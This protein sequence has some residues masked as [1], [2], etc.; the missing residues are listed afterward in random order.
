[1]ER[2]E[3]LKILKPVNMLQNVITSRYWSPR[4]RGGIPYFH[5]AYDFAPQGRHILHK[6]DVVASVLSRVLKIDYEP[7]GF[8]VYTKHQAIDFPDLI[9]YNAHLEEDSVCV[10]A[11]DVVDAKQ[12]VAKMGH[13]GNSRS[14]WIGG[15]PTHLHQEFRWMVDRGN[16]VKLDAA[17]YYQDFNWLGA[18]R[19]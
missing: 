9:F 15:D 3:K 2:I 4:I 14:R 1:V 6:Q 8:G 13:T 5:R 18:F 10:K 16:Y 19:V 7:N 11:G 17:L 12:I